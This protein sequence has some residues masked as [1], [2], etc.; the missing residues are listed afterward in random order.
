M[1]EKKRIVL[2]LTLFF[3]FMPAVAP[4]SPG[5]LDLTFNPPKGF[6]LYNDKNDA[7]WNNYI[8]AVAVQKDGRIVVAGK[9]DND[10]DFDIFVARYHTDGTLDATFGVG[11][12]VIYDSGQHEYANA[13]KI[14]ADG[15]IV[16]V[17]YNGSGEVLIL[18]YTTNGALDTTFGGNGAVTY[19]SGEWAQG[20]SVAIQS[21]GTIVVV[22]QSA[23]DVLILRYNS[24][25]TLDNTFGGGGVVTY[26]GPY[27]DD[28]SGNGVAIQSDGKILV[29][30]YTTTYRIGPFTTSGILVLRYT[31]NGTL[32]TTF[33]SD[34]VSIVG[35]NYENSGNAIAVGLEGNIF[36]TGKLD[37]TL[38]ILMYASNGALNGIFG[39]DGVVTYD[40]A[41][42]GRSLAVQPDGKVVVAGLA[43]NGSNY[44][45]VVLR[46][47]P[48]GVLDIAFGTNGVIVYDGGLNDQGNAMVLQS[49]GKI[50]V[51]GYTNNGL[52]DAALTLRYTASGLL[53]PLFSAD[54]V[55]T[56]SIPAKSRE[57]AYA[58]AVQPDGKIVVAGYTY[59]GT[60]YYIDLIMVRYNPDG[61]L[62]PGFGNGGVVRHSGGAIFVF[63]IALQQDGKIV[64]VATTTASTDLDV[65]LLRYNSNGTPDSTFGSGGVVTYNASDFDWGR[66][67]AIQPDGKIVVTGSIIGPSSYDLLVLR[68]NSNGTLDP[69]F[70]NGGVVTYDG[71]SRDDGNAVAIQQDGKIVVAGDTYSASAYARA[72]ILRYDSNGTP[73]PAFGNNG[74]VVYNSG[75]DYAYAVAV[76]PD[77]KIL[78][79]GTGGTGNLQMLRYNENGTLDPTF[80]QGGVVRY[81]SGHI[82]SVVVQSD[83]KIV[84]SG[85]CADGDVLVLRYNPDGTPDTTF[86]GDGAVT[87]DGGRD[88]YALSL[89]L[90]PDEKIVVSGQV[91]GDFIVLRFIGRQYTLSVAKTGTGSGTVTSAPSGISCGTDCSEEYDQS[92]SV[93]LTA[94]ASQDSSFTGWSGA[95]SSMS[96]TCSVTMNALKSVVAEFSGP[97]VTVAS[98]SGG[99][100]WVAGSTQTIRWTYT[101]TPGTKARIELFKGGALN[102]TIASSVS[103]GKGGTGSKTWKI[104]STQ[105]PGNDYTIKMTSTSNGAV[106]DTSSPFTIDPPSIT[107][108]SPNGDEIWTPGT[109]QT[110]SWT[111]T[112]DPGK[113]KIELLKGGVFNKT[114]TSSAKGK[115]GTGSKTWKI[116]STQEPGDDYTI[117]ITSK[118]NG[119]WSDTSDNYFTIGE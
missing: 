50:V 19:H 99:E 80:G 69:T 31:A 42:Q 66:G 94:K 90:Q 36:V 97:G 107:V 3:A 82:R 56:L 39:G 44:D 72:L 38:V 40:S 68:Y 86:G 12:I 64:V 81:G 105:T 15:K 32:D 110:I 104:P 20:N 78:V 71:G 115:N 41:D 58:V 23:G 88:D 37:G 103:I 25:G 24:N 118:T 91:L 26:N 22:G 102:Q 30:A 117:K 61:T 54:G 46:Y 109:P 77:Q 65:L 85:P 4:G 96:L 63:S 70:G 100:T 13:V 21:S 119:S 47:I 57:E 51:A 53:D 28:D 84:A 10:L 48:G 111:Y 1:R 33:S 29:A 62:D 5:D 59:D 75:Y 87:Y 83:G 11:G 67:V 18:R 27:N 116:P 6:V 52:V 2:I 98:P 101:G 55:A 43:Y 8:N 114:I 14:Q 92:T 45:L 106:S 49:D 93:T 95:C 108:T 74:V 7:K 34:G 16:V 113:V 79:G 35:D 73:D 9:L 89:A 17:G 60:F 76:Q 112:G